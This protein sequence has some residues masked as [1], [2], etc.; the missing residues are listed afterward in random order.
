MSVQHDVAPINAAPQL[1]RAPRPL[2]L[3]LDM[4]RQVAESNP[5]LARDA[6]AGVAAYSAAS[7]STLQQKGSIAAQIGGATL[8]SLGGEGPP[9]VLVPS[10]INPPSVLDLD[11]EVSLAEYLAANGRSIYIVDWGPAGERLD[12]SVGEHVSRLLLPLLEGLSPRPAMIG[13]C[14]GGTM[15]VAAANLTSLE[16]VVTIAAPW[17]FSAYPSSATSA[18]S[19]LWRRSQP[20][21]AKLQVLPIEILQAAFWSLDPHQ[22]VAKFARFAALDA[23]STEAKRF[24]ALE[25]WANQGEPLPLPA[26]RELLVEFFIADRPGR[27]EWRVDGQRISRELPVPHLCFAARKDKIVPAATAPAEAPIILDKGHVGMIVGGNARDLLHRPIARWL[28]EGLP[29][30]ARAAKRKATHP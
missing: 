24:I 4:I 13:Y 11:A 19:A 25:D 15:A 16:K 21:A 6:L 12:L 22:V 23:E 17:H 3:F 28:A 5:V 20:L 2:P 10:L 27:G 9:A 30:A 29:G 1:G 14:L 8:R 7:H 18:L 26:A